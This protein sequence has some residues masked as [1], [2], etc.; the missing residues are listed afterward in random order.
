MVKETKLSAAEKWGLPGGKLEEAESIID[1]V[2]RE[3]QEETG[4]TVEKTELIGIIN[5]PVTHEGNSVVK[6]IFRCTVPEQPSTSPEHECEFFTAETIRTL[7]KQG[8]IRGREIV[9]LLETEAGSGHTALPFL[10]IM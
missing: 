10:K 8:L 4:Y 6:F 3:I 2:C 9:S 1:G 5:K 7:D